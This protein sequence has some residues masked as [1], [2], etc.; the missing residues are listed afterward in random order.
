MSLAVQKVAGRRLCSTPEET[1][2]LIEFGHYCLNAALAELLI[3]HH[4]HKHTGWRTDA[5][6]RAAFDSAATFRLFDSLKVFGC[7]L[8][9]LR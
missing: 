7:W 3:H 1:V 4:A 9:L 8:V 6:H 2:G 5:S